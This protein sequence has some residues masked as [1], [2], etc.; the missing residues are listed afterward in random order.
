MPK[1]IY[2]SSKG[3]KLEKGKLT[4]PPFTVHE[5]NPVPSGKDFILP[6]GESFS[7]GLWSCT[8][9]EFTID[10]TWEETI[11]LLAGS[12]TVED[13]SGKKYDVRPG[14][15]LYI[16][17]GSRQKWTIHKTIKKVYVTRPWYISTIKSP[18]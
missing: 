17:K 2:S 3:V 15:F 7:E 18:K 11:Y 1:I 13:E 10:F 16:P 8:P 5:G 4:N 9:G 12:M 14:D 6:K